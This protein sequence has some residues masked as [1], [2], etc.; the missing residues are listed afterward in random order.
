MQ[1]LRRSVRYNASIVT[2]EISMP[3]F[4]N[5]LILLAGAAFVL[6]LLVE[7]FVEGFSRRWAAEVTSLFFA[8]LVL[9][10]TTGF[11]GRGPRES[12]GAGTDLGM[13]TLMFVAILAGMAARYFFYLRSKFR[14]KSFL[15]PLCASPIVLLP[16]LGTFPFGTKPEVIQVIAFAALAFQNGFFWK[17]IF[18]RAKAEV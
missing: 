9:H 11:P 14:W 5:L 13:V 1:T 3:A 4:L 6:I 7:M 8:L 16:L 2:L 15:K 10:L 18:E 17:V 12:F